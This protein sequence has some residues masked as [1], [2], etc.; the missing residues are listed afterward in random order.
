MTD[1]PT[2]R[3]LGY[4]WPAEWEPHTATWL[5]WPHNRETWPGKFEAIPPRFAEF[6]R[7]LAEFEPVNILAGGDAVMADAETHVG[8]VENVTLHDIETNDAWARDH[9]PMFLCGPQAKSPALADWQYNAWGGKHLPFEK[10]NDV[11]RRIA[12][13]LGRRHFA[14]DLVLEGGAIDGNGCG[15]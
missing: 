3:E 14:P 6:V 8:D 13:K 5:S 12:E 10:D 9:G 4:R 11:P 2:P 15:T 7:T 1:K